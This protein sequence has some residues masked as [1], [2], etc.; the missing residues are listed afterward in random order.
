ML[1]NLLQRRKGVIDMAEE[2]RLATEI[3]GD[4]KSKSLKLKIALVCS[5]AA[6]ALLALGLLLSVALLV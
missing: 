3:L 6:N 4:L 5:L 2:N 1:T